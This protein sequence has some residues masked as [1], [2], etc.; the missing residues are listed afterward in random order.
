[1][2][3]LLVSSTTQFWLNKYFLGPYNVPRDAMNASATN[4]S[5]PKMQSARNVANSSFSGANTPT[6]CISA[7]AQRT[8]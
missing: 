8:L 1:M 2:T 7:D 4:W 5:H 6:T 3:H